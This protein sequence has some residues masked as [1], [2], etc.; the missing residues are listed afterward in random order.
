MHNFNLFPNDDV[1]EDGEER[2]DGG[3]SRLS[4]YNKKGD[5]VNLEPISEIADASAAFV[6][7]GDDDDFMAAVDEFGGELIDVA[8]HAAGL[9]EKEVADHRDVV[10]HLGDEGRRLPSDDLKHC[11]H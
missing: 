8:F 4:V 11:D 1:S 3:H 6:C 9:G 10:W 7:M 5:V 2:E